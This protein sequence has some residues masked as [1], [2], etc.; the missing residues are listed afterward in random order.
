MSSWNQPTIAVS[1][2]QVVGANL[3]GMEK[4]T[5]NG[6]A[7]V[8][9]GEDQG[10]KWN[11]VG[12]GFAFI[13][14]LGVI[15]FF[16]YAYI[17]QVADVGDGRLLYSEEDGMGGM[18]MNKVMT[19]MTNGI[20]V[21][22][23]N[24]GH[25][26]GHRVLDE[27]EAD[28]EGLAIL[29][30]LTGFVGLFIAVSSLGVI[31]KHAERFIKAGLY[32]NCA[33]SLLMCVIGFASGQID[34]GLIGLLFFA[35]SY[36]YMRA[37][38]DRIPFAASNLITATSAIRSN[39]GVSIFAL[40]SIFVMILWAILWA[41]TS[42]ATLYILGECDEN[43]A[44]QKPIG[45]FTVFLFFVSFFWTVQVIKN[46]VHV[47][48]AGTVGRNMNF[49][50]LIFFKSTLIFLLCFDIKPFPLKAHGGGTL[51]KLVLSVLQGK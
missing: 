36:C 38:W 3:S 13:G 9:R 49:D 30:A 47:T 37:V 40:L 25:R 17:P 28:V 32:F 43:F 44:C 19:T 39:M 10:K 23:N 12:W 8:T 33:A 20:R 50:Q 7:V 48:V 42:Y 22:H 4:D 15:C 31:M 45:G 5:N 18:F 14:H 24:V 1:N 27:E 41:T 11:D 34:V 2:A 51:M 21:L 16:A 29:M 35:L 26:I 6:V 46:V